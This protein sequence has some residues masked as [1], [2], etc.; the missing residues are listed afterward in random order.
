MPDD[1][2]PVPETWPESITIDDVTDFA[3][4]QFV[5]MLACFRANEGQRSSSGMEDNIKGLRNIATRLDQFR[6]MRVR[7]WNATPATQSQT[8]K[9]D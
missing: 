6:R 2:K 3:C 9:G 7:Q 8:Q 1:E 4:D 5:K